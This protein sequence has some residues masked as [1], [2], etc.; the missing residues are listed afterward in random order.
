MAA[1]LSMRAA[2]GD[3]LAGSPIAVNWYTT[4]TR[5]PKLLRN[6]ENFR[7]M[8]RSSMSLAGSLSNFPNTTIEQFIRNVGI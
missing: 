1:K 7:I 5:Y 6:S 8:I 2:V 3:F 4:T